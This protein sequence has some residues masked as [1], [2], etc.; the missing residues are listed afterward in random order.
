MRIKALI[1]YLCLTYT[2]ALSGCTDLDSGSYI[3]RENMYSGEKSFSSYVIPVSLNPDLVGGE[4]IIGDINHPSKSISLS[5]PDGSDLSNVVVEFVIS[6]KSKVY[7]NGVEQKSGKGAIDLTRNVVYNIVAENG[8]TASY[9]IFIKEFQTLKILD[10]VINNDFK[11]V[12]AVY[13]GFCY[14]PENVNAGMTE[15]DCQKEFKMIREM[16]LNVARTWYSPDYLV[17]PTGT[18]FSPFDFNN[19]SMV[20]FCRW[21]DKMKELNVDVALQTGW[22]FGGHPFFNKP[23]PEYSTDTE[24]FCYWMTESLKYLVNVRGYSNIKYLVF[25]TEPINDGIPIYDAGN[26][27]YAN[28]GRLG[29][30][31]DL[32]KAMHQ[33]LINA[34]LRDKF[35]IMGPQTTGGDNDTPEFLEWAI[36]NMDD[37]FDIYTY[38]SYNGFRYRPGRWEYQAWRE[39]VERGKRIMMTKGNTKPFW[40]DEYGNTDMALRDTPDYGN[41]LAQCVAAFTNYGAQSSFLWLLFDQKYTYPQSNITNNDSFVDGVHRWGTVKWPHDNTIDRPG[42]PRPSWYAFSMM[43]RYLG[44]RNDSKVFKT[45]SMYEDSLFITAVQPK[46][47]EFAFMVINGK[48]KQTEFA[49]NIDKQLPK[50]TLYKHLY[51]PSDI[52]ITE[53]ATIPGVGKVFA[54]TETIFKD[55][56]PSRGVAIYTTESF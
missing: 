49:V 33:A 44:G 45:V 42:M 12:N 31:R 26:Y 7:A 21:L 27:R 20:A 50:Q 37:V 28:G 8:T 3:E 52:N 14:M 54:N 6:E 22:W 23:Y 13:H 10:E 11:G 19:P 2:S 53:S 46:P 15:A 16:G 18:L 55:I 39:Y 30:Y 47:G 34:G 29:F 40:I 9:T 43:S 17:G 4:D 24:R 35:L 41:Y 25:F 36:S 38:H 1:Y 32:G 51:D 5:I 56:L 48:H